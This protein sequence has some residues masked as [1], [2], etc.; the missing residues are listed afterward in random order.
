V[1]DQG[2]EY[3]GAVRPSP[4]AEAC[5]S[6][7]V[8][9][10]T[11]EAEA[12]QLLESGRAAGAIE[13]RGPFLCGSCGGSL[14]HAG[15]RCRCGRARPGDSVRDRPMAGLEAVQGIDGYAARRLLERR[16]PVPL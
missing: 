3:F 7:A 12:R 2:V 4:P 6:L 14:G 1:S 9:L 15:E 8:F 16:F 5:R 13:Y 11:S 10:G